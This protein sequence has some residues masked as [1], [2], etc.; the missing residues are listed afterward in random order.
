MSHNVA[1]TRAPYG[2]RISIDEW[3]LF[4]HQVRDRLNDD[5]IKYP[6]VEYIDCKIHILKHNVSPEL[7]YKINK[8]DKDI[9]VLNKTLVITDFIIK[10]ITIPVNRNFTTLNDTVTDIFNI[11]FNTIRDHLV[12]H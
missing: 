2:L 3:T 9:T 11:I 1:E 6:T 10:D 8:K 4:D 5:L 7:L 12:Y